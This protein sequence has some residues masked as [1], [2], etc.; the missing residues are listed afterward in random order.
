[1]LFFILILYFIIN[2]YDY[3]NIHVFDAENSPHLE[4]KQINLIFFLNEEVLRTSFPKTY[5]YCFQ[6]MG[7]QC[8]SVQEENLVF[9]LKP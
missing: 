5:L 1:M 4:K 6:I 3:G 2:D 9:H 8:A 7:R